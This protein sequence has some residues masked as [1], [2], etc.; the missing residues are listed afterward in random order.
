MHGDLRQEK[1]EKSLSD[2]STGKIKALVATDV[3]ARGIHVDDVDVVIHH[4]PPSD[5]KTYVHRSGRTARAGESGLVVSLVLWDEE[6]EVRKLMR[7]LGM[8]HP[9]VEVFSNDPR[10]ADLNAWDP[11]ADAA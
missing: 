3:A 8:K 5:A 11:A 9:I 1:R 10:L 4:D 2:F 6:L 7:R